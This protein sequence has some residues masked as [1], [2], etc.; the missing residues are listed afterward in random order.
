MTLSKINPKVVLRLSLAITFFWI[1]VLIWQDPSLWASYLSDWFVK[2]LPITP[3]LLL[4]ITSILDLGIGVLFALNLFTKWIGLVGV[5]HMIAILISSGITDVT[6]RDVAIMGAC[7]YM[8][9]EGR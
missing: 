3:T 2:I 8:F 4:K 5:I 1:G 9:S 7:Y 6:I